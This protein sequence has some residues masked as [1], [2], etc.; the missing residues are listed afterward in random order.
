MKLSRTLT[1]AVQA[2]LL[3]TEADPNVP[4]T[5]RQLARTG[6]MPERF[7]LQVLRSL[8]TA[9]I[10]HSSRGIRGGYRLARQADEITLREIVEA[11]EG[12]IAF[13]S[14]SGAGVPEGLHQAVEQVAQCLRHK[15]DQVT[16]SMMAVLPSGIDAATGADSQATAPVVR[17]AV[18]STPLV[19]SDRAEP[20]DDEDLAESSSAPP[21]DGSCSAT[22]ATGRGPRATPTAAAKF[23][24]DAPTR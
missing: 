10:L 8:V 6:A 12:R 14:P 18:A 23:L 5:C 13:D 16:L 7:L 24:I 22:P 2:M 4:C 19:M 15:L 17:L 3:L 20:S 9:G 11:V 21:G 1:Y